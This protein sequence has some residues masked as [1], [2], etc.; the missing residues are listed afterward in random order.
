MHNVFFYQDENGNEP[1]WRYL[2]TLFRLKIPKV[3]DNLASIREEMRML[4]MYGDNACGR[5]INS[6]IRKLYPCTGRTIYLTKM[7]S[8]FVLLYGFNK[9]YIAAKDT[10]AAEAAVERLKL[11]DG[12]GSKWDEFDKAYYTPEEIAVTNLRASLRGEIKRAREG[13]GFNYREL[14][15]LSGVDE[16]AIVRLEKGSTSL[17]IGEAQK[18]LSILGIGLIAAPFEED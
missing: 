13:H 11:G 1:V 18:V 6:N 3:Q 12:F 4:Q 5:R 17:P 8:G 7:P 16:D 9:G 10:R 15:R 2:H 14:R